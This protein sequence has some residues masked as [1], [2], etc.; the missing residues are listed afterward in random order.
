MFK[1]SQRLEHPFQNMATMEERTR[2]EPLAVSQDDPPK[3]LPVHRGLHE[4]DT[5]VGTWVSDAP[6][7][8]PSRPE[9]ARREGPTV[10]GPTVGGPRARRGAAPPE[11]AR[12]M[13]TKDADM[14]SMD[15]PSPVDNPMKWPKG[16]LE[17]KY[18]GSGTF[19]RT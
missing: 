16:D 8:Q 5:T 9:P 1:S 14:D 17:C 6:L 15:H 10:G 13:P 19:A 7:L 11:R 4:S 3:F 12:V 2:S 18:I